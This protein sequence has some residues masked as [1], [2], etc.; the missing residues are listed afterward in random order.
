MPIEQSAEPYA[1]YFPLGLVDGVSYENKQER[2]NQPNVET[3]DTLF[4]NLSSFYHFPGS[5]VPSTDETLL[6]FR[7]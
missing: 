7:L 4:T 5:S 3:C 1:K 6:W 2:T